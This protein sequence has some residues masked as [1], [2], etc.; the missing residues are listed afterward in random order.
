MTTTLVVSDL[1]LGARPRNDLARHG[2]LRAPLLRAV[3]EVERLVLLGDALELRHGPVA[4]PLAAAR[5]V[6][7]EAGARL[8]AG[9]RVVLVPGNHDHELIA[10]WLERVRARGEGIGVTASPPADASDTAARIAEW[11]APA[12]LELAYPGVWLRDGVYATHGHYLDVHITVPTFER[13]A[14]GAMEKLTGHIPRREASA[15]DYERVLTPLYAWLYALAQSAPPGRPA[16]GTGASARMWIK[17]ARNGHRP[18]LPMRALA[19]VYPLGI[20]LLNRAGLGPVNPDLSGEALRRG[21][22]LA[23]GESLRRLGV[24]AEHVV[25]G[26]THRAGPFADDD[27]A[28]WRTPGGARLTNAG[29]WV[30]EPHFLTRDPGVSPYWPGTAVRIGADGPPELIRLLGYRTHAD[31]VG[32]GGG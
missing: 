26:H 3:D 5:E 28:E 18:A 10:P 9:G 27:P 30:Y 14:I 12:T 8:G 17:L 21:G 31:F 13:L 24:E 2:A 20:A 4:E 22:L 32:A 23:L 6:L 29:S 7:A 25:F 11:V 16:G 15:L 1:H 19:A